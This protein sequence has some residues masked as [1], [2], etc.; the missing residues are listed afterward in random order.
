M[1]LD[2]D[3]IMRE[4]REGLQDR[5]AGASRSGAAALVRFDEGG[6]RAERSLELK[7]S[8]VLAELLAFSDRTFVENAYLAILRR[9]A[10]EHGLGTRLAQLRAGAISKVGVLG[11]LRWSAEGRSHGVHVDGLLV[12]FTLSK[13]RRRRLI[14]PVI[15]WLHGAF[16]LG[17]VQQRI[18]SVDA[19]RTRQ[20]DEL[21]S[22]LS[23]ATSE[24]HGR[25]A[26]LES[27]LGDGERAKKRQHE[28]ERSLDPLYVEFEKAFR[29]PIELIRE[30]AM[31]YIDILKQAGV[32]GVQAPVL[33]LGCGG[34]DW[35]NL[36]SEHGMVGTGIDSNT[37]FL[38]RCRS[39]GL[40]VIEG[41]VLEEIRKLP[42][43]SFGA[44]TGMHIAEHLPFTVLIELLDEC[45]RILIPG[46][47][48]ALETPN[49]ENLQVAALYFYNDPTHRNPLPPQ[50]LEWLVGARGFGDVE[51]KRWTIARELYA[52]EFVDADV[53]GA[54]AINF[55]LQQQR[56]A[57]DYAVIGRRA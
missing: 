6:R 44:V 55:L 54:I 21:D 47:V 5:A 43:S 56:N 1:K 41:D 34:G 37:T 9:P 28:F 2:A 7:E 15:G 18:D 29:G 12:P 35:L 24:L 39:R 19:N 45:A 23:A 10:D 8:Y 36:L 50:T 16:R 11:D 27:T 33:D 32:G 52:P 53:P 3:S 40:K 25:I 30:R 49:P 51:I 22:I 13:W 46:G 38:E 4:V 57:P 48:I 26:R 14:G 31:P 20:V 17:S 42:D